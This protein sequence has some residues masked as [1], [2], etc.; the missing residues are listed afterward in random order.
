MDRSKFCSSQKQRVV[1]FVVIVW[2]LA[3]T[4]LLQRMSGAWKAEFGTHP[5]EAAHYV[6]TLMVRDY[7]AGGFAEHPMR[8]AERY[9]DHYPKVAIG[10]YPPGFY[11][12]GS[13]WTL[14]FS[15]SRLSILFLLAL[16]TAVLAVLLFNVLRGEHGWYVATLGA[17]CFLLLP[18]VQQYTAIVMAD[19][20][21]ACLSFAAILS[22][23]RYFERE[24]WTAAAGFGLLASATIMTKTSGLWLASAPLL[25]V[26]LTRKFRLLKTWTFWMPAALVVVLCAPWT[27]ATFGLMKAGMAEVFSWNY[28]GMALRYFGPGMARTSGIVIL[29]LA[30]G[31]L[32]SK[33]VIP[34]C[35]KQAVSALYGLMG[36]FAFSVFTFHLLVPVGLET[37]YLLPAVAPIFVLALAGVD[38]IA[39]L[40]AGWLSG[41]TNASAMQ[42]RTAML[43]LVLGLVAW[44]TFRPYQKAFQGF[45]PLAQQV[46]M[47]PGAEEI[48]IS[49]DAP[50][51]GAFIAEVAMKENRPGHIVRRASKLLA[52]SDWMGRDYVSKYKNPEELIRGLQKN[53]VKLLVLDHSIPQQSRVPHHDLVERAVS[54]FPERFHLIAEYSLR[55][56]S[57]GSTSRASLYHVLAPAQED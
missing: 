38:A 50:G 46:I 48:L 6:T 39:K 27:V 31:G 15:P 19:M 1:T 32:I 34:I 4:L 56:S 23:V 13:V 41:L 30:L 54:G 40:S 10:H 14:L 24:H 28:L 47:K 7:L 35:Q 43:L 33:V 11:I 26:L 57:S 36:I 52:S 42:F 51:E 9:Y 44:E 45:A 22:L 55:R 20:L 53:G 18:L 29:L 3:L 2:L 5:D 8:F 21:V 12:L 37:R 17:S 49:S 16:I 25:G